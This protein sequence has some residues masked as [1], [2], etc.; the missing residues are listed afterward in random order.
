MN[1]KIRWKQNFSCL[2]PHQLSSS[3]DPRLPNT[4][5]DDA[6]YV[7]ISYAEGDVTRVEVDDEIT[8]VFFD[9]DKRQRFSLLPH[10]PDNY[11]EYL[12]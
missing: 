1:R 6:A 8:G 4:R 3:P 2:E 11:I 7:P 12:D 10:K 9:V 5:N